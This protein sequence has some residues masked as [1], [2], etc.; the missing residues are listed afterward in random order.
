[1]TVKGKHRHRQLM[2]SKS[3]F[4]FYF[5]YRIQRKT[6]LWMLFAYGKG[7]LLSHCILIITNGVLV[8][9]LQ[10]GPQAVT[11]CQSRGNV[12]GTSTQKL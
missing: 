12:K 4:L 5:H 9:I 7:F 11:I 3:N 6:F 2:I 8:Q 10:L 1:M